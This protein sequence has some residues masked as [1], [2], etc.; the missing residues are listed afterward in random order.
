M[1]A[2]RALELAVYVLSRKPELL[3]SWLVKKPSAASSG[4]M[5]W[6]K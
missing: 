6:V 2:E 5:A 3:S 1:I 4:V